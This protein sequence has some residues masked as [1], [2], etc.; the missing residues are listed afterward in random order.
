MQA[1]VE[2]D[3]QL[4]SHAIHARDQHR[5][6]VLG[7]VDRE[8]AAKAAN[9]AEHAAGKGLVRQILDALLGAVGAVD[10]HAGVGVGDRVRQR[11]WGSW[12]RVIPVCLFS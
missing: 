6:H 5:V 3:L 1:H 4:R 11:T 2:G 10:I 7:L 8:E 12:P 9:L